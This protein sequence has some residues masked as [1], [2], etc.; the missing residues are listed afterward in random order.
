MDIEQ[1]TRLESEWERRTDIPLVVCAVLFLI[2]YAIPILDTSLPRWVIHVC[3]A[4]TWITWGFL[5]VDVVGRFFLSVDR[6]TFLKRNALDVAS[7]ILPVLRPL[8]L[9]RLITLLRTFNRFFGRS[10]HGRVAVYV[11]SSITIIGFVASLAV[12][13]AER[14]HEDANITSFGDSTWWVMTTISTVGY[15]D[16]YP[17]TTAGRAIAGALMLA[18]LALLGVVTASLAAWIIEQVR[19]VEEESEI[20]TRR[21]VLVLATELR[22][23]RAAMAKEFPDSPEG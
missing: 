1:R 15:G 13:E 14:P 6:I 17:V 5:V 22:E 20:A 21:E 18:G 10:F 3:W 19:E 9:L 16:H 12:L 11:V 23:L 7:A 2:A 8:A 4:T